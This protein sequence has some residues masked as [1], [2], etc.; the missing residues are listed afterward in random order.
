[1]N[2]GDGVLVQPALIDMAGDF[3]AGI[4]LSQI[5]YWFR[6][7]VEGKT[8]LRVRIDDQLWLAKSYEEWYAETRM[9]EKQ[10]RRALRLLQS[11]GLIEIR[12]A[13]FNRAWT[14]HV[15]LAVAV[16]VVPKGRNSLPEGKGLATQAAVLYTENTQETEQTLKEAHSAGDAMKAADVLK[17]LQKRKDIGPLSVLW[18]ES[19]SRKT[20][21]F[22][23]ELTFKERGQLNQ[24]GKKVGESG[25]DVRRVI[26]YA[27][28][29]WSRLCYEATAARG[30]YKTPDIP[31]IGFLLKHYDIVMQMLAKEQMAEAVQ[32][33]AEPQP[34]ES[35]SVAIVK[36]SGQD[37]PALTLEEFLALTKNG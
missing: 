32:S 6:P 11:K 29:E 25:G 9:S 36:K 24:L 2:T 30:L 16:L 5:V 17:S 8:R 15:R 26:T 13:I 33:I 22:V 19:V 1:M 21:Q 28:D 27:V 3:Q 23:K 4:L 18:K 12:K 14:L 10:V 31:D 7:T 20:Q 35:P 34:G 37:G